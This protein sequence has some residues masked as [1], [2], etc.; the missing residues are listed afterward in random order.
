MALMLPS[1]AT[2]ASRKVEAVN[3]D[4]GRGYYDSP[5][6]D[7]ETPCYFFHNRYYFGGVWEEGDF[8]FNGA[9]HNG[10]YHYGLS[11]FYGG[12]YQP[13]YRANLTQAQYDEYS[14]NQ[15]NRES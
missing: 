10:R 13:G 14:R 8:V 6:A 5:P 1:C 4:R 3:S 9:L 12:I 2:S 7:P 15:K 11:R